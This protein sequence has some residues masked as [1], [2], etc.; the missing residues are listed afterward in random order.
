VKQQQHCP[1]GGPCLN[2]IFPFLFLLHLYRILNV[3]M[4]YTSVGGLCQ[5]AS[6]HS[7]VFLSD[8][9][10]LRK[11]SLL[12]L[13][14]EKA[15]AFRFFARYVL[16]DRDMSFVIGGIYSRR[17]RGGLVCSNGCIGVCSGIYLYTSRGT[18]MFMA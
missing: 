16:L 17:I 14:W 1:F 13:G 3:L 8:G 15:Y 6:W 4:H 10:I 12:F 7:G 9:V 5:N 2:D 11:L 18:A